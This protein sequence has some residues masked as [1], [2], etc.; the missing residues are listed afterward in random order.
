MP[1]G[2]RL[3]PSHLSGRLI[4]ANQQHGVYQERYRDKEYRDDEGFAEY[5]ESIRQRVEARWRVKCR[6]DAFGEEGG[7]DLQARRC[8][9]NDRQP[10]EF[11]KPRNAINAQC[12]LGNRDAAEQE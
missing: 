2:R 11:R 4:H 9:S 3:W 7:E 5:L 12:H 10:A 1:D 8:Q 6:H